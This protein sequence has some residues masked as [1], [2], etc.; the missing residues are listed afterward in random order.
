MVIIF[1][2]L[3]FWLVLR[4]CSVYLL[5][6][7]VNSLFYFDHLHLNLQLTNFF[8]R[9]GCSLYLDGYTM[10]STFQHRRRLRLDLGSG[11]R[12]CHQ[13]FNRTLNSHSVCMT[14][15]SFQLQFCPK[16]NEKCRKFLVLWFC[17]KTG[18]VVRYFIRRNL[19]YE[20]LWMRNCRTV[21][22]LELWILVDCL[23]GV[24]E[25]QTLIPSATRAKRSGAHL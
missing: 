15:L 1:F 25:A 3:V 12:C 14:Y 11:S 23:S 6:V 20:E 8:K 5:M 9:V 13:V 22:C 4:L 24:P 2:I 16:Y 7:S 19:S 17:V 18:Q 10:S 21:C